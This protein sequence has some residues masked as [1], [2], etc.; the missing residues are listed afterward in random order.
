MREITRAVLLTLRG[1]VSYQ[2]VCNLERLEIN[3]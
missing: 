1:R 3:R 2:I